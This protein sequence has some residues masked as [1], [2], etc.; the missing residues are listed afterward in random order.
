[1][2][3]SGAGEGRLRIVDA[4]EDAIVAVADEGSEAEVQRQQRVFVG[5]GERAQRRCAHRI[6]R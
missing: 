6:Q 2:Q 5:V 1:M 4:V 3:Q